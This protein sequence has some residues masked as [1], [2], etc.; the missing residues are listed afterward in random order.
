MIRDEDREFLS[1]MADFHKKYFT[2]P[3]RTLSWPTRIVWIEDRNGNGEAV[4]ICLI[5]NENSN[6]MCACTEDDHDDYWESHREA[7]Y[8]AQP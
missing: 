4:E 1:A 7:Q 3:P 2:P 5:C 6:E 8:E